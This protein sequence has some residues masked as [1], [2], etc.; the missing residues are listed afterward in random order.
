MTVYDGRYDGV[1][2]DKVVTKDSV[3]P[4]VVG[5]V[6]LG[7]GFLI[8]GDFLFGL[9]GSVA[10]ML[11][12]TSTVSN[13]TTQVKSIGASIGAFVG[14]LMDGYTNF[15]MEIIGGALTGDMSCCI[16]L[17]GYVSFFGV[18]TFNAFKYNQLIK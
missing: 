2:Y 1:E 4:F 6:V 9:L 12:I 14:L 16:F 8:S 10:G 3:V 7:L 15:S 17:L 11:G 18:L 5:L 13:V